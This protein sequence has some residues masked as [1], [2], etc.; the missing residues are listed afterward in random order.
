MNNLVL[1]INLGFDNKFKIWMSTTPEYQAV[2]RIGNLL[3]GSPVAN[4]KRQ[5][6][7]IAKK[8]INPCSI[9]ASTQSDFVFIALAKRNKY[10]IILFKLI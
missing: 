5:V 4:E 3:N 1:S 6:N 2:H 7:G 10:W 9:P 8:S